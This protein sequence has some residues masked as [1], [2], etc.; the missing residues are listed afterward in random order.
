MLLNNNNNKKV[1]VTK[2][3]QIQISKIPKISLY[4]IDQNLWYIKLD[5][6]SLLKTPLP[7]PPYKYILYIYLR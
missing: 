4:A 7:L 5:R 2:I 1:F 6:P 3:M